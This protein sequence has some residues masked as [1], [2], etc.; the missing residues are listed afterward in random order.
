MA[1]PPEDILLRWFN[2][3]LQ[4]AGSDRRVKNFT[5]DVRDAKNYV[6]LLHQISKE[7]MSEDV[8]DLPDAKDRAK[9]VIRASKDMGVPAIIQPNHITDGNKNLNMAFCAQIFNTNNGKILSA[10]LA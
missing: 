8:A 9:E 4:Q 3:H 1:L 6:T 10:T 2:Y 7:H 5:S